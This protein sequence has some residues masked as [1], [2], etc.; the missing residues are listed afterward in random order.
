M[1][2]EHRQAASP[3]DRR[4]LAGM[5]RRRPL[6]D[7]VRCR[8]RPDE[9]AGED[10]GGHDL[11]RHLEGRTGHA[12]GR[13]PIGRGAEEGCTGGGSLADQQRES[14]DPDEVRRRRQL[15]TGDRAV[16]GLLEDPQV[17]LLAGRQPDALAD[18]AE[19]PVLGA[20]RSVAR[21]LVV[22]QNERLDHG[23]VDIDRELGPLE[24]HPSGRR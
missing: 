4:H 10:R 6:E 7:L 5:Q 11:G 3:V 22:E 24:G 12:G 23:A 9:L 2:T 17:G 1:S 21:D 14:D 15:A 13:Q 8:H 19:R 16:D 18:R 20:V